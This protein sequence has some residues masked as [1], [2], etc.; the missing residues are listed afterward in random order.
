MFMPEIAAP[1]ALHPS[2]A[3]WAAMIASL[4]SRTGKDIGEWV[5]EVKGAKTGTPAEMRAFLKA[6]GLGASSLG[7]I[8]DHMAGKTPEAYDPVAQVNEL[9]AGRKAVL[10][11][12]YEEVLQFGL[13]LGPEVKACPCATMIPL[14]RSHVFA[15]MKPGTRS[16]LDLGLA[17]GKLKLLKSSRLVDTGGLAKKDRIT[18]RIE[19]TSVADFNDFAK[20]WL[21]RAYEADQP[22]Q[23]SQAK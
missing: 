19:L 5:A 7:L 4:K 14:Y 11:P 6:Q 21:R 22:V 23:G 8:V 16:R 9:F 17:L 15:Q 18:H 1:Y 13:E 10:L 2:F 20:D 3:H 12:I